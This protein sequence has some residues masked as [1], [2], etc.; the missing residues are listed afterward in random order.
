MNWKQIFTSSVG[1]K[2]IM[3]ATGIFLISFLVVHAGINALIFFNDGG[4]SFNNGAHFMG[5]NILIRTAEIGLMLGLLVHI[6]QGLA[7]TLQNRKLRPVGYAVNTDPKGSSWYSRSMGLLGTLLLLFL[8]LHFI[9]FWVPSRFGGLEETTLTGVDYNNKQVHNLYQ[10]MLDIFAQWWVV[11]IYVLGCI[12][13]GYHLLHG[14]ASAFKTLGFNNN[15]LAP[16]INTTGIAFSVIITLVFAS[17]PI[18][19]YFKW[20]S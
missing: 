8:I 14:F 9:H 5:T 4:E 17:M 7:L 13:L 1:K 20:V 12:S 10:R 3:G 11:V 18:A 6:Y 15:K 16:L 2:L 19:M